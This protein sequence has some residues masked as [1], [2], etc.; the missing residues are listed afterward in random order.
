LQKALNAYDLD[1][2]LACR[3]PRD[4]AAAAMVP[5]LAGRGQVGGRATAYVCRNYACLLPVTDPAALAA[6]CHA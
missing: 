2:V 4:E 1:S 5:L 3:P 6:H